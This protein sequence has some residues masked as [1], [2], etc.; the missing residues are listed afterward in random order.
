MIAVGDVAL[1]GRDRGDSPAYA[2]SRLRFRGREVLMLAVL[3]VLMLPAVATIAPLF[4]LLNRSRSTTSV[5]GESTSASRSGVGLAVDLGAAAVRDL[6]PQGLPRHDPEG[7]RGGRRRRRRDPQPDVPQDH[8]AAG[9][10]GARGDRVPGVRRRLDRV[11]LLVDVPERRRGSSRCRWRSTGW[12]GSSR[13][14]RRGREFAAFS[15]LFALPVSVVYFFAQKYI[16]GGLAVGG[17]K[18]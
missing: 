9:H 14:R 2:F 15:I 10:A 4:V 6:E 11:L 8:P 16:I 5:L 12:S 18:G 13:R 3:G 7:P 1:L 17:V